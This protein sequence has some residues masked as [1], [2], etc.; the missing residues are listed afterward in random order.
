MQVASDNSAFNYPTYEATR[1]TVCEPP[2]QWLERGLVG[3]QIGT[4]KGVSAW[5]IE[6]I[7]W[8]GFDF[9]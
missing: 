8:L 9:P 2:I 5:R 1:L 7:Q 6:V 4:K 3:F